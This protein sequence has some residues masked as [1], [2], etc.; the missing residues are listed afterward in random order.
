MKTVKVKR[1]FEIMGRR[2]AVALEL[3]PPLSH[4]SA[5]EISEALGQPLRELSRK[6]YEEL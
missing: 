6:G 1:Y 3:V 2:E 4:A 5:E